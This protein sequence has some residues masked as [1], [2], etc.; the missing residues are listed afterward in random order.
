M[1][2]I[3]EVGCLILGKSTSSYDSQVPYNHARNMNAHWSVDKI[4]EEEKKEKKEEL[5]FIPHFFTFPS[6]PHNSH[7]M[8]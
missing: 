7:S 5:V 4:R 2:L 6:S 3:A 1:F 8:R